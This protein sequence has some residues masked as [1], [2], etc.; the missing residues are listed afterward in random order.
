MPQF[1]NIADWF[2]W[3]D[4]STP[5]K[6]PT[7]ERMQILA[8]V[9]ELDQT[10]AKVIT[11]T[12]TNGKGSF[13]E[14]ISCLLQAKGFTA[15]CYT[16]PHMLVYNERICINHEQVNDDDLLRAFNVISDCA[17]AHNILLHFFELLTL[18]AFYLFKQ[19]SL[20]YWIL[21]VGI[22]GRL[23]SVNVIGPH[24]AVIT[25]VGL[26]HEVY[27]GST[28]ESIATEKCG[29]LRPDTQLLNVETDVPDGLKKALDEHRGISINEHYSVNY[30][31]GKWLLHDFFDDETLVLPDQGL[32][33]YSLGAA[34]IMARH[35]L[36]LAFAVDALNA[37][38]SGL[39]LLGRF[40]VLQYDEIRLILDIT[41]NVQAAELLHERLKHRPLGKGQKRIAVFSLLQDKDIDG[42]MIT[43]L[44]D[45][46]AWFVAEL[47]T[48][49]AFAASA[50]AE[51]LHNH[52][53]Y[54]ISVS[55]NS[56]QALARAQSLVNPGDEIVVF[57]SFFA[58]AEVYPKLKK[59][60]D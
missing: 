34:I 11:V 31:G 57:G 33:P 17:S 50:I 22:G 29:I 30:S 38:L 20:D 19:Q 35:I 58:V 54:M 53:V 46:D 4:Q 16:S 7:L 26:D 43:L 55:K 59:L 48:P 10:D 52:G 56:R 41:H 14:A 23:D 8:K 9:L 15:G 51:K 3:L 42:I 18:S 60:M 13:V 32:S 1:D 47:K 27:L 39:Y 37:L 40:Q 21:E 5:P 49:R 28:R 25:S 2:D 36:Q 12:G 24:Y 44:K 45:F 6:V